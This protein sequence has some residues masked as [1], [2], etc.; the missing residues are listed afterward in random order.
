MNKQ[1]IALSIV[2]CTALFRFNKAEGITFSVMN[3]EISYFDEMP[4]AAYQI[5]HPYDK[6]C[7]TIDSTLFIFEE[8]D[9]DNYQKLFEDYTEYK[10]LSEL[11]K[12]KFSVSITPLVVDVTEENI[13]YSDGDEE[14]FSFES[15]NVFE[16][17]ESLNSKILELGYDTYFM[18]DYTHKTSGN[19]EIIKISVIHPTSVEEIRKSSLTTWTEDEGE[20]RRLRII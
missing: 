2:L 5:D 15:G 11:E 9:T 20:R 16:K 14:Q 19:V 1:A 10:E 4:N 18:V 3:E 12:T 7:I 8:K 6:Y 13:T 17:T